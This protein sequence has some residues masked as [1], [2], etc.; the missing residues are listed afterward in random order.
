M[1]KRRRTVLPATVPIALSMI[2]TA[3]NPPAAALAAV[4]AVALTLAVAVAPALHTHAMAVNM[5]GMSTLAFNLPFLFVK[6]NLPSL[7]LI[8]VGSS[9]PGRSSMYYFTR[10][11]RSWI[12][13]YW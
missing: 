13:H 2:P 11:S 3:I 12:E 7:C 6:K 9:W 8:V 4:V 1:M 10:I 5:S